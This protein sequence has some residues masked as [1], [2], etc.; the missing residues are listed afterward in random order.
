MMRSVI[1]KAFALALACLLAAAAL[2]YP[3]DKA[4]LGASIAVV[5]ALLWWRPVLWLL[6]VPALLPVLDF[7]PWT[8]WFYVDEFDLLLLTCASIAYWRVGH[9]RPVTRLPP[10]AGFLLALVALS[11]AASAVVGLLPLSPLDLNAFSNYMSHFNS[12]RVLKGFVWALVLLPLLRRSAG[13]DMVNLRSYF[14][15]G[16]LLGLAGAC[17]A[18][19]WER[20]A[21]PG[22][23]NFASDY[24]P[25]APFSAMHTGGAS[26]DAYLAISFPFVAFWLIDARRRGEL[27]AGALL[28]LLGAFAG[29]TLFSRDIYLAYG[30][31]LAVL[32]A[33]SMVHRQ[34]SGAL[35]WRAVGAG[36]LALAACAWVA[37]GLFATG[38][39]RGLAAALGLFV[40]ALVAATGRRRTLPVALFAAIA[41]LLLMAVAALYFISDK[42]AYLGYSLAAAVAIG[43]ALLML[44]GGAER[45]AQGLAL[46]AG[47]L[48]ALALG[49][50]LVALHW[51]GGRALGDALIACGAAAALIAVNRLPARPLW[52]MSRPTLTAGLF[53]AIICATMIPVA[54]SYYTGE[55]FSTVGSDIDVRLRHWQEALD[56]MTPTA[57]TSILGM[58][59]GRY[60][61]TY[62]WNNNHGE[63][64]GSYSFQTEASGN[65]MLRLGSPKYD[66]GYGEVLR[67]L[68]R[69]DLRPGH[70][71]R[72]GM[73]VLRQRNETGVTLAIC[74]R[75]L[76]YPQNCV[77]APF[78]LGPVDGKWQHYEGDLDAGAL[79]GGSVMRLP[80]QLELSAYGANATVE[81]DNV[82]LVDLASGTELVRNGSFS[83]VNDYWFFSSDRNH[84]P[85][86]IKNF[87]VNTFFEMG[88]LGMLSLGL[89]LGYAAVKLALRG[90]QGDLSASVALAAM[91]AF[92]MV[93]LFDSLFDV[94][95]LTLVFFLVILGALLIPARKRTRVRKRVRG[96]HD[97]FPEDDAARDA[98]PQVPA[99]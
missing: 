92:L 38:G 88:A 64:P 60:P 84:F 71:Y 67:M 33:L 89:L 48:P 83:Q 62:F 36:A 4:A 9:E 77:Q 34:R 99:T 40:A 8:G 68:Q 13:V 17:A 81:V 26:L 90:V 91:T 47:A 94:P 12:L 7:A 55:R 25:T 31:A 56:M 53:G 76:L 2:V 65:R 70:R 74:E 27:G 66:I 80:T 73:D 49:T 21:F 96:R 1:S 79:G 44:A 39:Y 14:V 5:A 54:G 97:A 18:V 43:G 58:G 30:S 63:L 41:L 22:L 37:R 82:S 42:G 95:R 45:H 19:M 11:F 10:F 24:R 61:E 50:A 85:W 6:I 57:T 32:L 3:A 16:M 35:D 87:F 86:H 23:A 29:L 75:W 93:G 69:V 98:V 51:G 52:E 59:L 46:A 15:P 72:L 20:A 78:K 28:L